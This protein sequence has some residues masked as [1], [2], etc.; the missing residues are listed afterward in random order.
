MGAPGLQARLGEGAEGAAADPGGLGGWGFVFPAATQLLDPIGL[1]FGGVV[2]PVGDRVLDVAGGVGAD[3]FKERQ[4]ERGIVAERVDM[5][6]P[7]TARA[8]GFGGEAAEVGVSFA[9][10]RLEEAD[11]VGELGG[12]VL[13]HGH[14]GALA[15]AHVGVGGERA[16]EFELFGEVEGGSEADQMATPG[17]DDI[18][19]MAL[20]GGEGLVEGAAGREG[21][22]ENSSDGRDAFRGGG[23]VEL[24]E[25]VR[26]V[27]DGLAEP[28][29]RQDMARE[30]GLVHDEPFGQ[31]DCLDQ[32]GVEQ[33]AHLG[34][35]ACGVGRTLSSQDRFGDGG[36]KFQVSGLQTE[37]FELLP[38]STESSPTLVRRRG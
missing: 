32:A 20:E 5:S 18:R 8:G 34:G 35:H 29:I 24:A 15:D 22:G 33:A 31:I 21:S 19:T 7:D 26:D 23:F 25:G 2:E 6:A 1:G 17:A 37:N 10:E 13:A 30:G 11:G 16:D 3:G 27:G 38:G 4:A 12:D 28:E 9:D 36:P 14:P